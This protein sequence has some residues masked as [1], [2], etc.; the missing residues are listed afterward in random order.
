MASHA[1]D[2]ERSVR[3][4]RVV[5]ASPCD[6]QAERDALAGVLEEL[7]DGI[8]GE[9][10]LELKLCRWE[11]EARPAV[12]GNGVQ[13]PIDAAL[14]IEDSDI[15]I[16]IFWRRFGTPTKDAGSGTE[17][18]INLACEAWERTGRPEI[19]VYFNEQPYTPKS[20][21]EAEQWGRVL[22][23]RE[24][25]Q[26]KG[27]SWSYDG[28][29]DF[30]RLV[31]RHLTKLLRERRPSVVRH[32]LPPPPQVFVGRGEDLKELLR[33]VRQG[34]VTIAGVQGMG[35]VG[36]SALA[37]VLAGR[38][39][40]GYPD[41]Q[42]FVDLKGARDEP[43][44][45][46]DA[47]A[48]VVHAFDPKAKLPDDEGAVRGVYYSLLEGK[49]VLLLMDDARDRDQVEPLVPPP[50]CLLIVTSRRRFVLPGLRARDL[51]TLGSAQA[52][53]L[54]L[55]LAP[56]LGEHADE[57]ARLCGCL[58]L[59]LRVSAT[60]LAEHPDLRAADLLA[61]L[62]DARERLKL[63]GAD[64]ALAT[65][66]GLLPR[67]LL[68][69]W[70][71][72]AVFPGDFDAEGAAAVWE[73]G[74]QQARHT[75]SALRH[76]SLVEWNASTHRYRLHELARDLADSRLTEQRGLAARLRHAVHYGRLLA[77]A[78]QLYLEGGEGVLRAL[79]LFDLERP[80]IEGGQRWAAERAASDD[81]AAKLAS[82][83]PDGGVYVLDL[84]LHPR[85]RIG[86]LNAAVAAARKRRRRR[87]EGGHLGN[88]GLAYA[89]LGQTRKA[90]QCYEEY[91]EIA[92]EI[93]DRR[94]EANA[95]GN[96]GLT[97]ADLGE[98]Q[99]AIERHEEAL[100]ISRE[101]GDRRAE[102]QHLGNLG[103]AYAALGQTQKAIECYEQDL[104]IARAIGD[105]RGEAT[106]SWNLGDEYA[107]QG[108]L[109]RAV[110][111]MQALVDFMREIGHADAAKR[112]AVVAELRARM[113]GEGEQ[114]KAADGRAVTRDS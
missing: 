74:S 17:H 53:E 3:V 69:R 90:M 86:W 23:F 106:A 28:T 5:V 104:G 109:A 4:L 35:G 113:E 46:A 67:P 41:A 62:R 6:V 76:V 8:A 54:L 92:R 45:P 16:G 25:F 100:A 85:E 108:D 81:E 27:L 58:P 110:D 87:D 94:G 65:S 101:L 12:D 99:R 24:R 59:A 2:E 77:R 79:D 60:A 96:L 15:L 11:I 30:V 68:S 37:L 40:P 93:G 88:L 82:H 33:A 80:N 26:R 44:T 39:R 29:A 43:L 48:R 71:V 103:N 83:Y 32:Q 18:E 95:V 63:T 91:L 21:E 111:A 1:G 51:G 102:G 70:R 107:K 7:N 114:E 20:A 64:A 78:D 75:L 56:A 19:M 10:G 13:G 38:L 49:R 73:I 55:K 36:K 112:A 66:Y 97:Y 14:R 34:G 52:R 22:A 47:M 9:L 72:L 89:A 98:I 50:S 84:R 61:R 105:R 31:R 42:I 57:V